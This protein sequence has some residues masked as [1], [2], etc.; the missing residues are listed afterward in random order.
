[1]S[2]SVLLVSKPGPGDADIDDAMARN[3]CRCG[4]YSRIR[5]A[6]KLTSGASPAAPPDALSGTEA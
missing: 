5:A 3:I 1:M 6:I 2:A 4:I